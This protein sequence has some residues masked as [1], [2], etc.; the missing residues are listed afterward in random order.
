MNSNWHYSTY[1]K[2]IANSA[3]NVYFLN[4]IMEF[5]H[6]KSQ[7]SKMEKESP[8]TF[9]AAIMKILPKDWRYFY[10]LLWFYLPSFSIP[11]LDSSVFRLFLHMYE[12]LQLNL[13]NWNLSLCCTCFFYVGLLVVFT[14][15]LYH[16]VYIKCLEDKEKYM[17]YDNSNILQL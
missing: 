8:H 9:H 7:K 5:W 11:I 13:H 17:F 4:N 10:H 2:S 16:A 1:H 6:T 15:V 12:E 14:G 3:K